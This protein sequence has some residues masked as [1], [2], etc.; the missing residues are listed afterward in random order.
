MG[1][2][3]AGGREREREGGRERESERGWTHAVRGK[4]LVSQRGWVK[5]G[6][7]GGR[8]GGRE[9]GGKARGR[10]RRRTYHAFAPITN[11]MAFRDGVFVVDPFLC[12]F[13]V[14]F[15]VVFV[16]GGRKKVL[17]FGIDLG[18]EGGGEGGK[19]GLVTPLIKRTF[20]PLPCYC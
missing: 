14:V 11:S 20:F 10:K 4:K 16:R 7:K 18:K 8:E 15:I 13:V 17:G 3:G 2:G 1:G 12:L 6:R 19:E 5:D 9:E